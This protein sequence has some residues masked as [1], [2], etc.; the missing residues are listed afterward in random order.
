MRKVITIDGLAAS[1][2]STIGKLLAKRISYVCFSSGVLYRLIGYLVLKESVDPHEEGA[3]AKVIDSHGIDI[4]Q[5]EDGATLGIID[6]QDVTR[7]LS[8]PE[9][10]EATS[11]ISK[12]PLVRKALHAMQRNAFPGQRLIAE[13]RDMG[14]IIFPDAQLKF[15]IDCDVATRI[16]RRVR[17][18]SEAGNIG[19]EELKLLKKKMEIEIVERDSRDSNRAISPTVPA[20]DAIHIM[21][22]GQTLTE[23]VES[24]YDFVAKRGL[25]S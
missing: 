10:S 18:L 1:G 25:L 13:G 8:Q 11:L 17:Q 22:A 19:P 7:Y 9:V 20:S 15:F 24:M 23:V 4:A 3:V 21:N 2:K 6:G 5:A 16:D 14:T 12:L